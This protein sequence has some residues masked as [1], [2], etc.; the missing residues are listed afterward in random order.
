MS[1]GQRAD[2]PAS[3]IAELA[4]RRL[5]ARL[6]GDDSEPRIVTV[7]TDL[8]IRTSC[9]CEEPSE[10]SRVTVAADDRDSAT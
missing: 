2:Q 9:G 3:E 6:R 5:L 7:G 1:G 10:V 4:T 8:V